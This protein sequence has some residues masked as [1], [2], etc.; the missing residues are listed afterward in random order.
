MAELAY[1]VAQLYFVKMKVGER[2]LCKIRKQQLLFVLESHLTPFE[3]IFGDDKHIL[4]HVQTTGEF[5]L[6]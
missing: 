3:F 4:V 2:D 6:Y 1:D 5:S